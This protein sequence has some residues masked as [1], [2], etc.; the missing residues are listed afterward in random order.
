MRSVHYPCAN[1]ELAGMT[2]IWKDSCLGDA[3]SAAYNIVSQE[4]L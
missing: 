1:A 2:E 4:P 3:I